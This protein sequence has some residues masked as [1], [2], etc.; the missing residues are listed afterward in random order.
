M[1]K[2]MAVWL[3]LCLCSFA[4][5]SQAAELTAER[6]L[7]SSDRSDGLCVTV[8][9]SDS[10]LAVALAK[11][12]KFVLQTL[13]GDADTVDAVRRTVDRCGLYGRVSARQASLQRLPYTENLVNLLIVNDYRQLQQQGMTIDEM[14]RV[15]APYGQIWL[16]CSSALDARAAQSR[17]LSAG[18]AQPEINGNAD[19]WVHATKPYPREMDQ[20]THFRHDAEGNMVARDT[21]V[22][23]PRH[24]QWVSGPIWQRHHALTPGTSTLVAARGRIFYI[25]DES[26]IGFAGL[27]DQWVLIARDAFNG[28]L[29]WRRPIKEWGDGVWSWWVG[30]HTARGNHPTHIRKRLVTSDDR[31]FVTLGLQ[32]AC[33]RPGS[34]DR[35]DIA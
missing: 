19:N 11:R 3:Y 20:W 12:S 6:I 4:L 33:Q 17:L 35:Q 9:A 14:S 16:E 34:G 30:G 27:P 29:L 18:F 31:V 28:K 21:L 5:G 22:G 15:I 24:V 13:H 10:E 26:P 25:Q 7:T 32:C 8:N 1:K 23:P 2:Q